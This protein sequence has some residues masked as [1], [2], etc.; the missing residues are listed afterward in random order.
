MSSRRFFSANHSLSHY[1]KAPAAKLNFMQAPSP[2]AEALTAEITPIEQQ[3]ERFIHSSNWNGYHW[4]TKEISA[5][6]RGSCAI[7]HCCSDLS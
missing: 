5:R 3:M 2:L 4:H 1:S 6:K 7:D